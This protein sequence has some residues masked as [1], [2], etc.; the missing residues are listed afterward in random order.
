MNSHRTWHLDGKPD[1]KSFSLASGMS[2]TRLAIVLALAV[3]I[4]FMIGILI[5]TYAICDEVTRD[6]LYLPGAPDNLVSEADPSI[7][8]KIMDAIDPARIEA[9]LRILSEFP[10]IAGSQR[11]F[12]LVKL[13]KDNFEESGLQVQ[14]TPYDVLLS[15][16]SE[17]SPNTVRLLD[18]NNTVVYD[19]K[20]DESNFSSYR[21][22]VPPFNA[23]SPS[24]AVEG[25]LVFAGYGRVEDYEW[26]LT[27]GVNVSGHLVIV[28]YGHIFRG[29]KVDIAARYGATGIIIY[30]DP[31]DC[32]GQNMGDNRVYPETWWLP[33]TGAQ[34]G[35]IFSGDGD[36]ITPGYPANDLAYRYSE[37][38]VEPP[39]PQIPCHPIGYGAA[40]KIL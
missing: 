39:M 6:G 22:V 10:H 40:I 19:A 20:D 13:L 14:I 17:G 7:S 12:D 27:I 8:K 18:G 21:D 35:T 9:N 38:T 34:R 16:P 3:G 28:K 29:D 4:G 24:R 15:Y 11:D 1:D 31:A 2:K 33:P 25:Q 36:P 23:Y 30:S 26:L 37:E 32:T 5:G